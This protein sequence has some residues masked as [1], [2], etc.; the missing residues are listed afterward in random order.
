M[1]DV[2][3]LG[4]KVDAS[5][6]TNAS[7][8]LDKFVA[9]GAKASA[10]AEAFGSK[11][12]K[13]AENFEK[14]IARAAPAMTIA[15]K[16]TVAMNGSLT[17]LSFQLND[18]ASGLAM[19]QSPFQL[20]AQQGGQVFQVW[21]QNNNVFKEAGRLIVGLITPSRLLL[22]GIGALGV[23]TYA[24]LVSWKN[25]ALA[26]DDVAKQA[27]ITSERM[28]RLQAAAAFKGIDAGEFGK[29]I[30]DFAKQSYEAQHNMGGLVNVLRANGVPASKDFRDNLGSAA[31]LIER[32]KGDMQL[33]MSLLRQ[34]GLPDTAEWVR[35]LENGSRGIKEAEDR[36]KAF[37]GAA[38]DEMVRKA[39][40]FDEA[41]N[42]SW[43]NFGL[44]ARGA[45]I[46][47]GSWLDG[48]DRRATR[49]LTWD[50]PD[51]N[52]WVGKN[53]LKA[54]Q[55][56]QMGDP[57]SFY[58]ATGAGR[59]TSGSDNKPK[60]PL[61]RDRGLAVEQQMISAMGNLATIQQMVRASEISIIQARNSGIPITKESERRVLAYTQATALGTLAIRQ[62]ADAARIEAEAVGL[63]VG[64]ATAMRAEQDRLA[65]FRQ[66]GIVLTKAQAEALRFEAQAMGAAT[67]A[68][69][70]RRMQS[71]VSFEFAQFG[72][73]DTEASIAA[74]LRAIYGDNP[75]MDSALA[76]QMRF[77]EGLRASRDLTLDITSGGLKDLRNELMH[78]AKALDALKAAGLNAFNKLSDKLLDMA[79]QQLVAKAFGGSG[80]GGLLSSLFGID[81][82]GSTQNMGAGMSA[83]AVNPS[84]FQRGGM[85]GSPGMPSRWVHPS[86]YENAPRMASG[87]MINWGAGERPII[88][89]V[90]ERVLNRRETADYN[91][92]RTGGI[93]VTYA[94][95]YQVQGSGPEIDALR[96]EIARDR[97]EAPNRIVSAVRDAKERRIL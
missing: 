55:G 80:L 10:A 73:T 95:V 83:S 57:G 3:N 43:A 76:A 52:F 39:R 16:Q 22:G 91:A 29:G 90:G 31:D 42:Q 34:M 20:M 61:E 32:G 82:S 47:A 69:A 75:N 40:E 70:V 87:G 53:L 54:G 19:G 8:E 92:G 30:G 67:E 38:H 96:Q 84:M 24:G 50:N 66:R 77:N 79:A 17:Q 85:I 27:G 36:A 14:S 44:Q 58:S 93:N 46:T 65:D 74:R 64:A 60:N 23:A 97:A 1:T 18:I 72:R 78:D 33:Q 51:A 15:N 25:Y 37:G 4:I 81:A 56:T 12:S 71:D 88:G 21:Q 89:H 62:A 45:V 48:L 26:L 49:L 7:K 86:Y 94:P 59:S 5:G 28:A 13:A 11:T 9:M 68:A 63:G 41:W 2:A 6:V 35:L